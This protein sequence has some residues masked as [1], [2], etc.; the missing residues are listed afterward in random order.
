MNVARLVGSGGEGKIGTPS[1]LRGTTGTYSG[2][3]AQ[4][5]KYA[6][7]SPMIDDGV[8]GAF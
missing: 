5:G 1:L 4:S 3:H 2:L 8:L 6:F 7:C